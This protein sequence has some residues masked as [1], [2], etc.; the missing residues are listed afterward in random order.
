AIGSPSNPK[1]SICCCSL[2]LEQIGRLQKE[3]IFTAIWGDRIVS[4]AALS[5]Q[6]KAA[7]KALGDDGVTQ[8][9]IATVH[10]RGF[11]FVAPIEN[12]TPALVPEVTHD[13][14]GITVY[15]A[16]A[17]KPSVAILPFINLNRDPEEDHFADGIAEDITT[18]L[19]KNRWLTVIA[20]NPAFAFR[21][22]M[23]RIRIIGEKLSAAYLVTGSVRKAGSRFRITVQLVD[24][25]TEQGVWSERFD[26]DAVDIFDLQD[27][28]SET[29]AA[30]IEASS[31]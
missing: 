14:H 25:D 31:A 20:R 28:I 3:E 10:G 24:S 4:D 6:I 2:G 17:K 7:R 21:G 18:A 22:S 8:H 29:V 26:R 11:R 5:S 27:E 12:A 15:Q 23:D 1:C 16:L 30:R 19:S 13:E 9:T